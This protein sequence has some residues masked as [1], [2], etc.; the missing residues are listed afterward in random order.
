MM[1]QYR[2]VGNMVSNLVSPKFESQTCLFKNQCVTVE[3][4]Y[5]DYIYKFAVL[6]FI[7][8]KDIKLIYATIVFLE[9]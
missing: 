4:G 8:K 5:L 6:Q 7:S 9:I 3:W 2:A 1:Q